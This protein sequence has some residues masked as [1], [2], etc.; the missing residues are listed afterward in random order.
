MVDQVM[1]ADAVD[2]LPE[3][4][5]AATRGFLVEDG[6]VPEVSAGPAVVRGNIG[7]QQTRLAGLAP[8]VL[9]DVLLLTPLLIVRHHLALDEADDRVAKNGQ[10][11]VHPRRH[12]GSTRIWLDQRTLPK[13]I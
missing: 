2:S 13:A 3:A 11:I 10:L 8:D 9:A 5:D 4:R 12:I 6:F 7:A 1:R